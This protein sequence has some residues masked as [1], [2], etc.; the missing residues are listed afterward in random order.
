ML[1]TIINYLLGLVLAYASQARAKI[2]PYFATNNDIGLGSVLFVPG[3]CTMSHEDGSFSDLAP[4]VMY[5]LGGPA[6]PGRYAIVANPNQQISIT[7]LQRDDQGDGIMF[8]PQGE[9]ISKTETH[10]L[11]AV[12][13]QEIDSGTS[14]VINI[15]VGGRL[16]VLSSIAPGSNIEFTLVDGIEWSVVP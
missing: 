6:T 14:R 12:V 10:T 9:V 3:Y 7:L 8:I 15:H 5:G 1:K 13:A 11:T 4:A 16:F 2:T